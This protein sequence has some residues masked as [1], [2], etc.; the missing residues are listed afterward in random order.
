MKGKVLDDEP[1][2]SKLKA[3][4]RP[5]RGKA[6]TKQSFTAPLK[7]S[8]QQASIKNP[9]RFPSI[10]N[11]EIFESKLQE[12]PSI[13]N[14][15]RYKVPEGAED[16]LFTYSTIKFS[17]DDDDN[18]DSYDGKT[19]PK[20]KAPKRSTSISPA[21]FFNL[22]QTFGDKQIKF[23]T[24]IDT[25]DDAKYET[26]AGF[27]P[28]SKYKTVLKGQKLPGKLFK[29]SEDEFQDTEFF[30]FSIRPRP[31]DT[32]GST[33]PG[34]K[35]ENIKSDFGVK[36]LALKAQ[37]G[38]FDPQLQGGFKPSFKLRDFP[39]THGSAAGSG[40]ASQ[41]Q[42]QKYYEDDESERDER[43]K[44]KLLSDS[45]AASKSR[46]QQ[47]LKAKDDERLEKLVEEQFKLQQQK[48]ITQEKEAE[49]NHQQHVLQRQKEKLKQVEKHLSNKVTRQSSRQKRRPTTQR[50]SNSPRRQRNPNPINFTV[51]GNG[52]SHV[53]LKTVT[54][55]DGT[56]RVSFNLQ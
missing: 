48:K 4:S 20:P 43:I 24:E 46:F 13:L 16:S 12:A 56:Y 49:L 21:Q 6:P 14:A 29:S 17:G 25:D 22:E 54:G 35:F 11:E 47:F 38:K 51:A 27:K 3:K 44:H 39:N 41:A 33:G 36:S 5:T 2:P 40:I 26:N 42:I 32:V 10:Q 50:S 45:N 34:D 8:S 1:I 15:K 23:D 9:F 52:Q 31:S 55:K 53:P 7:T 19:R 37:K 30:D 28:Y 18:D